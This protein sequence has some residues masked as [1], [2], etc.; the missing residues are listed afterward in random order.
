VTALTAADYLREARKKHQD[1]VRFACEFWEPSDLLSCLSAYAEHLCTA[2]I[3]AESTALEIGISLRRLVAEKCI[4]R[5]GTVEGGHF[6]ELGDALHNLHVTLHAASGIVT[7]EVQA[8]G[9]LVKQEI[10]VARWHDSM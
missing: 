6:L 9:L 4:A 3:G 10:E 2:I 5:W 1:A 7:E 8:A